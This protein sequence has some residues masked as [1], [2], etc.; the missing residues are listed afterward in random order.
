M[1]T[2]C[3]VNQPKTTVI[4][5]F[6]DDLEAA[7]RRD[8]RGSGFIAHWN[9]VLQAISMGLQI[10]FGD[11]GQFHEVVKQACFERSIAVNGNRQSN[12]APG[13]SLYMIALHAQQ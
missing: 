8:Y 9:S 1:R 3:A 10:S 2:L 7:V 12:V 13:F 5:V 11:A 6:N 4:G